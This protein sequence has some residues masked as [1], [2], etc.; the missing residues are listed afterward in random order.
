MVQLENK[1]WGVPLLRWVGLSVPS[2][3]AARAQTLRAFHCNP[4]RKTHQYQNKTF[5]PYIVFT[6][7]KINNLQNKVYL[8]FKKKIMLKVKVNKGKVFEA[9]T[10]KDGITIDSNTISWD[11]RKINPNHY[12]IISNNWCF[13]VET[14]KTDFSGKKFTFKIN[15]MLQEVS[16]K[17]ELDLL[18]E[19]MGMA[20][21]GDIK[22]TDLKA[23]MPGLVLD[24]KV[25]VGQTVKKGDTVMV[26]EAMKM[27]NVLKASG[28]GVVK[29]VKVKKG[30]S[31][32]KN[33]VMVQF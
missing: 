24:V 16:V 9:T 14:I 3:A 28:E 21:I 17:N 1:Y 6:I 19:K 10:S 4:S 13:S 33:Q 27:E 5:L 20:D 22:I 8:G 30:E 23:P 12:H 31:V 7:I 2:P 32:E 26:L 29:A 11:I 25:I 18:L 15:G